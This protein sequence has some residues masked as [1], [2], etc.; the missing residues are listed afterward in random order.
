MEI[1]ILC[2]PRSPSLSRNPLKFTV[3][4]VTKV[5]LYP[6]SD[7]AVNILNVKRGI[8]SALLAPVEEEHHNSRMVSASL[9]NETHLLLIF[10][11]EL[12]NQNDHAAM[13]FT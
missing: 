4:Q 13:F 10:T 8:I 3:E 2:S 9:F 1:T 6:T 5:D 12:P 11:R 7:E